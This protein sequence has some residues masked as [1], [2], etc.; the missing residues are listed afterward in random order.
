LKAYKTVYIL[1]PRGLRTGGP[2]ALHQLAAA[3]R[4]IGTNAYLV[5]AHPTRHLPSVEEYQKYGVP[6]VDTVDDEPGNAI[7]VPECYYRE[8]RHYKRVDRF[9]WWLSIDN[10]ALFR[11][12]RQLLTIPAMGASNR[13]KRIAHRVN[14]ARRTQSRRFLA[15]QNVEH[16]VQSA[17]AWA[18]LYSRLNVL[19]S[20]LSDYTRMPTVPPEPRLSSVAMPQIAFNASKGGDLVQ[21]VIDSGK[22][23]ARWIPIVDMTRDEVMHTLRSSTVYLDLGHQ[24]GKDRLPREAAVNG[25]IT[26]VARRGAGA[27]YLDAPLPP[28][29][30][31]T[32]D[33]G[34]VESTV[35]ALTS[36]FQDTQGHF[37][38]QSLY[39]SVIAGEEQR[40]VTEAG[41]IFRD[42]R[43]GVDVEPRFWS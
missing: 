2:E 31:I 19:P 9:C 8:L 18:F 40:F 41:S 43:F 42:R 26:V 16:L 36:V 17:Y 33:R 7:V 14:A 21:R 30:K 11:S 29:H 13:S 38:R 22:L 39:R 20:M 28:E 3:L 37:E 27:F 23:R 6:E 10:S 5:P 4:R 1:Y 25:A 24:P 35:D 34:Y 15:R 12:E 32:I